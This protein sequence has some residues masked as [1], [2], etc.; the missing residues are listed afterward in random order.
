MDLPPDAF[1]Q[2]GFLVG[3]VPAH[4]RVAELRRHG[5]LPGGDL[6]TTNVRHTVLV[7]GAAQLP[8]EQGPVL[9]H[10][11]CV[12]WACHESRHVKQSVVHHGYQLHVVRLNFREAPHPAQQV[13][14][15]LWGHLGEV[16]VQNDCQDGH[17]LIGS[18]DRGHHLAGVR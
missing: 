18:T 5:A 7:Q 15:L 13:D 12:A 11:L 1:G 6:H 14:P 10:L 17:G 16:S 3:N 2:R 8:G 4:H 9:H